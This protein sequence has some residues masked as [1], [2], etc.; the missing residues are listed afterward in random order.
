MV[1]RRELTD[2]RSLPRGGRRASDVVVGVSEDA[3]MA[4]SLAEVL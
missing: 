3:S 1:D 4:A 2:R